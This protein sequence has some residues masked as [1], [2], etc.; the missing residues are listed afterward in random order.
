M[1]AALHLNPWTDQRLV[2]DDESTG[3]KSGQ[4]AGTYIADLVSLKKTVMLCD[5]CAPKFD[6]K[7]NGYA[8]SPNIPHCIGKCD[9]CKE[10]GMERHLFLH[11]QNMP[12]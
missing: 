3:K 12:R 4:T 1:S 5:N 10:M 6:A 2:L 9:G 7:R 8:T 11:Q